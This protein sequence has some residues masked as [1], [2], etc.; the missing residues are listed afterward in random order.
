ME[1]FCLSVYLFR[2]QRYGLLLGSNSTL[3]RHVDGAS[4]I[5]QSRYVWRTVVLQKKGD[6]FQRRGSLGKMYGEPVVHIRGRPS[7]VV[8]SLKIEQQVTH[9]SHS[10]LSQLARGLEVQ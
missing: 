5:L 2:V 6:D 10:A 7:S 8:H 1:R 3:R 9:Q 4:S